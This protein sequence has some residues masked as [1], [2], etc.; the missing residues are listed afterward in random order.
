MTLSTFLLGTAGA[1]ALAAAATQLLPR[2]VHVT[3]SAVVE[4]EP[5]ELL[6]ILASNAAYQTI[7][8]YRA[9][10]PDLKIT[11][12][13]P[14]SGVGSG[15]HFDGK[16]GKGSQTVATISDTSVT[17]AIDLGAMGQPM[18]RV[19]VEPTQNGTQVTWEMQADMGRNPI[20]RTIGLF[21]DRMVGHTF[22]RGI[23]NL[24]AAT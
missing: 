10:D 7:N 13:G 23:A 12:F 24:G 22:E 15:F 19:T 18:Q 21:M 17:Y 16:D 5:A 2:H 4:A 11:L 20:G 8:P 6:R 1:L 14:E 9:A 3:R